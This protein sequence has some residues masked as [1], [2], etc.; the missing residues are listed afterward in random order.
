MTCLYGNSVRDERGTLVPCS[1][2]PFSD[3]VLCGQCE[4]DLDPDPDP[5]N[6]VGGNCGMAE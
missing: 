1:G 3:E 6:T 2:N 4:R 5:L